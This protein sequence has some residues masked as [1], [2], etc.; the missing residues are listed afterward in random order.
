[1]S[2]ILR[3]IKIIR[4]QWKTTVSN[5]KTHVRDRRGAQRSEISVGAP[6]RGR[7]EEISDGTHAEPG[8]V[9]LGKIYR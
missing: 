8:P 1:M 7:P 4:I 2:D 3:R 5:N 6:L 9:C